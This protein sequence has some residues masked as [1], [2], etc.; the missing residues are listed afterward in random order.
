MKEVLN[1]LLQSGIIE[2]IHD[3]PRTGEDPAPVGQ[4]LIH[5]GPRYSWIGRQPNR[6][7]IDESSGDD[8]GSDDDQ[9]TD[10]NREVNY[11]DEELQD[12]DTTCTEDQ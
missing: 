6:E 12:T 2:R 11:G 8:E 9:A 7:D 5:M 3:S 1:G 4:R 10:T